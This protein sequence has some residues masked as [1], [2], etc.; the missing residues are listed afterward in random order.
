[1]H[2]LLAT[3][4]RKVLAQLPDFQT[5]IDMEEYFLSFIQREKETLRNFYRRFL[6]L[7]T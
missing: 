7:K 2:L 6:Q 4:Q 3:T 5:E 1:M